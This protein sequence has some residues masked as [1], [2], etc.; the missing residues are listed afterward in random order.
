MIID[1]VASP[2]LEAPFAPWIFEYVLSAVGLVLIGFFIRAS[3]RAGELTFALM[4]TVGSATM[5]WQEW[6]ADWGAYLLYSPKFHLMPW[7]AIR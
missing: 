3:V 7:G 4:V 1:V 2:S 6:Y 5:W